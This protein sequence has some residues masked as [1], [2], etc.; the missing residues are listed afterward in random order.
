[1]QPYTGASAGSTLLSGIGG[2]M[3]TYSNNKMQQAQ[4]KFYRG[5]A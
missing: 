3:T 5:K 1:M 2:L 4:M